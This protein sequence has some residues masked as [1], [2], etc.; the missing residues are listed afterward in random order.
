MTCVD[1]LIMRYCPSSNT[2][3]NSNKIFI[4]IWTYFLLSLFTAYIGFNYKYFINDLK[5]DILYIVLIVICGGILLIIFSIIIYIDIKLPWKDW[6]RGGRDRAETITFVPGSP[7]IQL[8]LIGLNSSLIASGGISLLLQVFILLILSI[9]VYA[10]YGY[11]HSKFGNK[12]RQTL[13]EMK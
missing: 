9:I 6:I 2:N 5:L 3:T 13:L 1:A 8:I 12:H 7:I 10:S 4:L 11:K